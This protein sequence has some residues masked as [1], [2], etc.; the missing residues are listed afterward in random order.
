MLIPYGENNRYDLVVEKKGKFIRIQAK[1]VT[2]KDG[3]LYV[4]CRSSNNWSVLHYTPNQ[5][6]VI[7]VFNPKQGR[8]Y[9]VPVGKIRKSAMILRLEPPKNKQKAKIRYAREFDGF[10]VKDARLFVDLY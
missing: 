6:D 9:Y 3:K 8:V 1:Y 2:P 4:N 10:V 5:I 7:A